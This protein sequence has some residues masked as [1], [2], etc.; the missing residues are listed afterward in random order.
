MLQ[1]LARYCVKSI[2]LAG[3]ELDTACIFN[4]H[5]TVI[6]DQSNMSDAQFINYIIFL[7]F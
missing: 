3:T 7:A 6:S 1:F 2:S 4:G 5:G